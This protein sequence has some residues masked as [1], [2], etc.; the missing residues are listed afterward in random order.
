MEDTYKIICAGNEHRPTDEQTGTGQ[1]GSSMRGKRRRSF[2]D[3]Q[4]ILRNLRA[5][6]VQSWKK[7]SEDDLKLLV[8]HLNIR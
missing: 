7:H 8:I 1:T 2:S 3:A 4:I 6:H 5:T